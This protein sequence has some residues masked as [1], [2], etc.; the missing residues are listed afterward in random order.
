MPVLL[1]QDFVKWEVQV[2]S[3]DLRGKEGF[4]FFFFFLGGWRKGMG[5]EFVFLIVFR[6]LYLSYL[7]NWYCYLG[8]LSF[9]GFFFFFFFFFSW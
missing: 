8:F 9:W 1:G 2:R 4:F 5:C 3:R 7:F 6:C